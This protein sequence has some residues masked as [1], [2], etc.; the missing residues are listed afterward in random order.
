MLISKK[1]VSTLETGDY[2]WD[3]THKCKILN[4]TPVTRYG[5]NMTRFEVKQGYVYSNKIKYRSENG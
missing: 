2:L 4:V 3:K 5:K 1:P